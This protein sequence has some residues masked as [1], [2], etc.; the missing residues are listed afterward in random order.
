M[1]PV[2]P[3]ALMM[4]HLAKFPLEIIEYLSPYLR[5][6]HFARLYMTGDVR[7]QQLLRLVRDRRCD[8][9]VKCWQ[10]P[11]D[12][13]RQFMVGMA[14]D[15]DT[16]L[17]HLDLDVLRRLPSRLR[18][19]TIST[20]CYGDNAGELDF[21]FLTSLEY[22]KVGSYCVIEETITLPESVTCVSLGFVRTSNP[23][24]NLHSLPWLKDLTLKTFDDG[25]RELFFMATS[26]PKSLTTMHVA[27]GFNPVVARNL[28]T[29][30]TDLSISQVVTSD[31]GV[32]VN[33]QPNLTSLGFRYCTTTITRPLPS[34]LTCIM[35]D[36][37]DVPIGCTALGT[38]SLLPPSLKHFSC[39][40]L[41]GPMPGKVFPLGDLE[42]ALRL[43]L[44]QLTLESIEQLLRAAPVWVAQCSVKF[45][46]LVEA[47]GIR[48]GMKLGYLTS[49]HLPKRRAELGRHHAA[50][51]LDK[52]QSQEVALEV[53]RERTDVAIKRPLYDSAVHSRKSPY[54]RQC[55]AL[56]E[57][58]L[59]DVLDLWPDLLQEGVLSLEANHHLVTINIHSRTTQTFIRLIERNVLVCVE[60]IE[61][62]GDVS[63]VMVLT[64]IHANRRRL[65]RLEEIGVKRHVLF[66]TPH[67]LVD[68][69][70]DD[71]KLIFSSSEG[72]FVYCVSPVVRHKNRRLPRILAWGHW[73]CTMF[74]YCACAFL[75]IMVLLTP[76]RW[77]TELSSRRAANSFMN[78]FLN[79]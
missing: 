77:A 59:T 53:I 35:L 54:K 64:A 10:R 30:L 3:L 28:P 22:F 55:L 51:I 66:V 50:L 20:R 14:S 24:K 2:T 73:I 72:R 1:A 26:W 32:V 12:L 52:A 19:L 37:L 27:E 62:H 9:T 47:L 45:L 5:D 76:L 60:R 78:K 70:A 31:V 67:D 56:L 21:S 68:K 75:L 79:D 43:V 13:V 61:V 38:F 23:I 65:P 57:L 7:L 39:N 40:Q 4:T 16:E 6:H 58:G 41:I 17:I 71:M 29:S 46:M 8:M 74:L 33:H 15:V 44:P 25:F 11:S 48:H 18:R 63:L 49:K 34:S 42:A 69:L 36:T